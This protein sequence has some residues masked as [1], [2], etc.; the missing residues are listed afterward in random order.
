MLVDVYRK[1]IMRLREYM[2]VGSTFVCP[3]EWR[4]G[5]GEMRAI[6]S[7]EHVL[8]K[9]IEVEVAI[10][11]GLEAV[12]LAP[13]DCWKKV[14]SIVKAVSPEEVDELEKKL[15]HEVAALVYVVSSKL[16]E[17]CGKY[18]HL[19]ATSYDVVDT[20]WALILREALTVVKKKLKTLIE[21]M[22]ELSMK[23]RDVLMVGR[24]HGKHAL[25][26][27]FG[28]K[29]ANYVYE[30]SRSYERIEE[31][32]DR[33]VRG[34]IAG[35]VGTMAGWFGKGLIVEEVA[36]SYLG[37]K[38]HAISTQVAPRDGF[39]ELTSALAILGSQLDRFA[40]EVRKLMRDEIAEVF[41]PSGEVGSSAMPHKR[42]PSIAERVC[43]LARLLRGLLI[44][45]LEDI[46]L[47]HERDLTNSSVERV[48]IPHTF[49]II[50]QMLEDT[51][52]ILSKLEVDEESMR[53][54]LELTKGNIMSECL[55]S[56]LVIHAGIPR[57][58]AHEILRKLT[59]ESYEKGLSLKEVFIKSNVGKALPTE[60]INECF[61]YTKY[62]GN[63]KELI[64]RSVNYGKKALG[65]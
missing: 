31:V 15:G 28:F 44:A 42:N 6:F 24:T 59:K 13:K 34:K 21:L 2:K 17:P 48:L 64:E 35:A 43:G 50:D 14:L 1:V 18:V 54:N 61:D 22:I 26:I 41:F 60:E 19:G 63:Y 40:L 56:K 4:Y 9:M 51:I 38:P 62:L 32:E 16:G 10:M 8:E 36:L 25:P 29:L 30:F 46:P 7:R 23:Y 49:L 57:V 58:E 3:F 33:V 39:A 45:A 11:K 37:L 12:E 52:A 27:T 55:T 53:R 5:S 20:A 47:M 65:M